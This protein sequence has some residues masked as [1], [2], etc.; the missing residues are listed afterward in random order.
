MI[1]DRYWVNLTVWDE[2]FFHS[3]PNLEQFF[4]IT[5]KKAK[6]PFP[7]AEGMVVVFSSGY[8]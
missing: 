3:I 4:R 2:N 1:L 7:A 8:L 6:F 5:L